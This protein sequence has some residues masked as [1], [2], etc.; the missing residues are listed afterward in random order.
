[1]TGE[2]TAAF[3]AFHTGSK[4]K[5]DARTPT[6]PMG[7]SASPHSK[8]PKPFV[9]R[10]GG[11]NSRSPR[12][13][14]P[15]LTNRCNYCDAVDHFWRDCPKRVA[16]EK[17]APKV[18]AARMAICWAKEAEENNAAPDSDV[19]D[20]TENPSTDNDRSL[21]SGADSSGGDSSEFGDTRG[22]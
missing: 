20:D 11:S 6:G 5:W 15:S 12:R 8:A 1:M 4:P 22:G 9:K 18:H 7:S 17:L 13:G 16:D 14:P 21:E 2:L 10:D 3:N 19:E